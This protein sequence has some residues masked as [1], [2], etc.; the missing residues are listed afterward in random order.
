MAIAPRYENYAEGWETGTRIRVR[1]FDQEQEVH[2]PHVALTE[3][4]E[5]LQTAH[6]GDILNFERLKVC[7]GFKKA[8]RSSAYS[9]RKYPSELHR[10]QRRGETL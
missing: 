4:L 3:L 8:I 5:F 2:P 6:Q 7:T 10:C 1:V 9:S